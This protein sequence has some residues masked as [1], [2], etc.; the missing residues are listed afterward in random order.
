METTSRILIVEDEPNIRLIF[1]AALEAGHYQLATAEDGQAALESLKRSPVDLVLLDLQMPRVGGM[2][3]LRLLRDAGN[4]VPVVIITAHGSVPDAVAAM[5]LGAVDFL[6]KPVTP[7]ALRNV[8][9]DVLRR[10]ATP[11]PERVDAKPARAAAVDPAADLL[12]KAKRSLNHREFNEADTALH[13]ALEMNARSAEAHYLSGV[14][15]ELREER[16]AAYRSYQAALRA[17]P[18]YEPAKM[19]LMKYFREKIM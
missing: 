5:K 10:H 18:H 14:L 7:E 13:K 3:V 9:A 2:E 12:S 1:R 19:H 11:R 6:G 8:V 15:H 4:D 16:D 17:D